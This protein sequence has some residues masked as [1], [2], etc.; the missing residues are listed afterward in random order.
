ML[1][2]VITFL[3]LAGL[4]PIIPTHSVVVTLLLVNAA[5]GLLLLGVIGRGVWQIVQAGRTGRA[6]A[7]LYIRIVG[8]LSVMA[9]VPAILVAMVARIRRE[10]VL[11]SLFAL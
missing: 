8:R 1:S 2:A 6:G 4:T 10:R 5:T 11:E 7:S 9:A 3:V